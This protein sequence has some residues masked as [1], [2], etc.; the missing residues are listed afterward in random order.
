MCKDEPALY[1]AEM[2]VTSDGSVVDQEGR[3]IFCSPARFV[4]DI[5]E[6]DHCFI[7]GR[8]KR[9]VDFNREHVLPDW[10]LH[11]FNLHRSTMT[12]PNSERHPYGTYTVPCCI[13]CNS[14]LG[15]VFE[16]PISK[17]FASGFAGIEA[18]VADEGPDR[19]FQ[20]LS[21]IFLKLHL[22]DRRLRKNL[23]RRI[24]E[25]PIQVFAESAV[26]EVQF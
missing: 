5:C 22:K 3:L 25:A 24:A 19:L 16:M 20:W 11:Q 17:A 6:G 4:A 2:P 18:L 15:E 26:L 7:C 9:E 14:R 12:L 23:D 10:M 1:M 21:L 13:N 8:S